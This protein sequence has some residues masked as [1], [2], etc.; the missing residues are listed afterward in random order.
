MSDLIRVPYT[1][2]LQRAARIRQ[3]AETIRAEIRTLKATIEGVQWMG[4]RAERFFSLWHE[5]LPDMEAW[6]TILERFA[7]E[8]EEQARR[9]QAADEAF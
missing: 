1:E 8:L 6:A 3:E 2:L 5:T 7:N 9:I 4:R